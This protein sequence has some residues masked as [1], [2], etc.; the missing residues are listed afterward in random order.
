MFFIIADSAKGN[1]WLVMGEVG[2]RVAGVSE[3]VQEP[4]HE[5][6]LKSEAAVFLRLTVRGLEEKMARHTVPYYKMGRRVLFKRAMLEQFLE[7]RCLVP[8][9]Q[10]LARGSAALPI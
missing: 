3:L 2:S 4:E 8:A 10:T 7:E 9:K 6:M 1:F 5:F